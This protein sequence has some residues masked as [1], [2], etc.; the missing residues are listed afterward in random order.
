MEKPASLLQFVARIPRSL[1]VLY[2]QNQGQSLDTLS[3]PSIH[4]LART[5]PGE[6]GQTESSSILALNLQAMERICELFHLLELT[7]PARLVM[8]VEI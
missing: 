4:W 3:V 2:H 5:L 7:G 6:S 1:A 8:I